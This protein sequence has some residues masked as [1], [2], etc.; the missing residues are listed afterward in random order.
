MLL[1]TISASSADNKTPTVSSARLLRAHRWIATSS[2][3]ASRGLLCILKTNGMA[4]QSDKRSSPNDADGPS[5]S[6]TP[7]V[8]PLTPGRGALWGL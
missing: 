4:S 1:A 8:V 5:P 7:E 6:T 2:L 3:P